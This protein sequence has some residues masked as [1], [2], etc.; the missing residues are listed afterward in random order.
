MTRQITSMAGRFCCL[1]FIW[2]MIFEGRAQHAVA[3]E[4]GWLERYSLST[5][6]TVPLKQLIPG[7]DEYYYYW[8]LHY[9]STEQWSKVDETLKEWTKDKVSIPEPA[10]EIQLRYALLT[11]EKNPEKTLG[12]IQSRLN[13]QFNHQ[14]Q[15]L[16]Q[17]PNL[18]TKL[19]EKLI[20][21]DTLYKRATQNTGGLERFENSAIQWLIKRELTRDQVHQLLSRLQR[22]D[23]DGLVKLV[24]RWKFIASYCL[25]S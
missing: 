17:K 9:L 21:S 8:S 11:Y 5:D 12:E 25:P 13:V 14:Q 7:T 6:R 10:R 15:K 24:V 1:L 20:S 3:A 18:P 16:N 2:S 19:D 4:I 23:Y 22:P